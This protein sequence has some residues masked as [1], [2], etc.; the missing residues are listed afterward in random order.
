MR[1]SAEEW[2]H[3]GSATSPPS[4]LRSTCRAR[5]CSP[6][7][8]RR[9][10]DDSEI[11]LEI[12]SAARIRHLLAVGQVRRAKEMAIQQVEAE[13]S[14]PSSYLGRARVL[15][16]EGDAH[17]AASACEEVVR[18][19]PE[20]AEG[21][22]LHGL[23]SFRMGRFAE[24][25][26][27]VIEAIRLTPAEGYLFGLYARILSFCG[28]NA[29]ALDLARRALELDPDDEESHRLFA[30]LLSELKPSRWK[31]SEELARRAVELNPED[32]DGFAVLGS[33][34]LTQRRYDEAE[35]CFRSALEL[36]PSNRLA[37][38]G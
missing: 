12:S 27:D 22:Y 18:R 19:A 14:D 36:H 32:D 38:E 2:F 20:W 21:W 3:C 9:M 4:S 30:R 35:Q 8:E 33:I 7:W 24:A 5:S 28:K 16:G 34:L 26:R 10:S 31:I 1:S 37:L 6:S 17:G 13:P 25:E 11:L 29:E 15:L 23:A